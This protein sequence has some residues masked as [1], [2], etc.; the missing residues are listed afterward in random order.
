MM[1]SIEKHNT[2][3][4]SL[5]QTNEAEKTRWDQQIDLGPK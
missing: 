5:I 3:I 2:N 4:E 1:M